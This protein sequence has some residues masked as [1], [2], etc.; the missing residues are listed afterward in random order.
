MTLTIELSSEEEDRLQLQAWRQ[1][2]AVE[3]VVHA[4]VRAGLDTPTAEANAMERDAF[5]QHLLAQGD[6]PYIP[7]RR[8]DPLPRLV[9]VRG[10][11]VSETIVSERG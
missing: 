7:L 11:P 6:I 4:L 9:P 3:A 10:E 5:L 1:G 2:Q 8:S